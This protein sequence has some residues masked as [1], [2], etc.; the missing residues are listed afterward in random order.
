MQSSETALRGESEPEM[1][2]VYPVLK[3]LSQMLCKT[4]KKVI[5]FMLLMKKLERLND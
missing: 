1:S 3:Y 4:G 2:D 5:F